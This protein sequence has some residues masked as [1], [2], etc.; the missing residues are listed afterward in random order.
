MV[1]DFSLFL[2]HNHSNHPAAPASGSARD[3]FEDHYSETN[4]AFRNHGLS[5]SADWMRIA[6]NIPRHCAPAG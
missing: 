2:Y 6:K 1:P 4:S 3:L 5:T